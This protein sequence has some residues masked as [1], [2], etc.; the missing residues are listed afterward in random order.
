MR[1]D[2]AAGRVADSSARVTMGADS[3]VR[4]NSNRLA[5]VG[6]KLAVRLL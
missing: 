3:G 5:E 1:F 6:T 2:I 4:V